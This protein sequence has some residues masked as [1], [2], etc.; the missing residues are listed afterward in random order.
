MHRGGRRRDY[1]RENAGMTSVISTEGAFF[2]SFV[3]FVAN[4]FLNLKASRNPD[5]I[6]PV[7]P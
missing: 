6:N 4:Y 2:V 7:K 1:E 5:N 3:P